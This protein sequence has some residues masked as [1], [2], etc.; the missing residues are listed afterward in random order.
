MLNKYGQLTLLS[1]KIIKYNETGTYNEFMRKKPN[2]MKF[3]SNP[4]TFFV[5]TKIEK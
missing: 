1:M 5:R 3:Q 2:S 4:F